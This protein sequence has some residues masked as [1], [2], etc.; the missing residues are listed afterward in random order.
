MKRLP[1]LLF[2]ATF[3]GSVTFAQVL[4][5]T[6]SIKEVVVTGTKVEVA[7]KNIPLTVS[8]ITG[9]EIEQSDESALLPLISERVP[10]VFITE[11]GITGFGVAAGAAGQINV[12]GLGGSPTTQVLVLIDGHPQFMGIMGHHL[13]DAYIAS[14]VEKVEIVRGP[15][16]ILYGS[17]AMGGVINIIT[18]KQYE[19]G[20]KLNSRFLYGSYNTQKYMGKVGFKK[21][22]FS[23]FCSLN[24][25]RTDGHRDSSDFK[26]T[27]GYIKT[28]YDINN[29]WKEHN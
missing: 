21:K 24:H 27:N 5:D 19:D 2:I 1:V 15:A 4:N 11:R 22:G 18:K 17:N 26:I 13:P 12:R 20:I 8:V 14:D 16:S 23:V 29:N 6:I 25:D 3:T 10:G 9:E 7:R 28:G